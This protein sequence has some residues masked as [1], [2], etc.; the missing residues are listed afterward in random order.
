MRRLYKVVLRPLV[1]SS[2]VL[3]GFSVSAIPREDRVRE[4]R[5]KVIKIIKKVVRA[6]GDGLIIPTPPP[7]P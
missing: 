2:V 3:L 7:K 1:V 4:P 6:L 5:E